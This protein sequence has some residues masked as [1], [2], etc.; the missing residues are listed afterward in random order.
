MRRVPFIFTRPF[1]SINLSLGNI[2]YT[3]LYASLYPLIHC[4]TLIVVTVDKA[5]RDLL[6]PLFC[7]SQPARRAPRRRPCDQPQTAQTC[8]GFEMTASSHT[9]P[10]WSKLM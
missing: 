5:K 8:R 2:A 4:D 10:L 1:Q 9:L 3:F 6:S 7:S